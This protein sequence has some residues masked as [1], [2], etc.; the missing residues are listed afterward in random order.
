M[1]VGSASGTFSVGGT[2]SDAEDS[3]AAAGWSIADGGRASGDGGPGPTILAPVRHRVTTRFEKAPIGINIRRAG[4]ATGHADDGDAL[5]FAPCWRLRGR[6][7]HFL[8]GWR[9]DLFAQH[10]RQMAS[11]NGNVRMIEH[12]RIRCRVNLGEGSVEAISQLDHLQGVHTQIE[13]PD[14]RRRPRRQPQHR[15]HF[16]LQEGH[17]QVLAPC[18]GRCGELIQKVFGRGRLVAIVRGSSEQILQLWRTTSDGVSENRPVHRRHHGTCHILLPQSLQ[19]LEGLLRCEPAA[20][21]R[22]STP[23]DP[24]P[25]LLCLAQPRP[26]SPGNGLP[27]EPQRTPM[28]RELIEECVGGRMVRLARIAED[29]GHA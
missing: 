2:A 29:A 17:Q 11:K 26:R 9:R 16:P 4:E 6:S 13:E 23:G 18:R 28:R 3:G 7:W 14:R 20:A 5:V 1:V 27:R 10:L 21:G 12:Q 24:L 25:L 19:R 15:L 22:R 8:P